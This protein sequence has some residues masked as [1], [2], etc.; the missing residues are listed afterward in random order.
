MY[1]FL[2]L[3]TTLIRGSGDVLTTLYYFSR[4]TVTRATHFDFANPQ[5]ILRNVSS[6]VSDHR[7]RKTHGKAKYEERGAT[8]HGFTL[9]PHH[10]EH[11]SQLALAL[12]AAVELPAKHKGVGVR[13]GSTPLYLRVYGAHGVRAGQM[14]KKVRSTR[15]ILISPV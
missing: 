2:S 1:N 15:G 4:V 10:T 13:S 8:P 9:K 6:N 5:T 7:V 14:Q 3:M 11:K 12:H